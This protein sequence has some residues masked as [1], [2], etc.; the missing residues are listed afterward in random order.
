M[1]I[2]GTDLVGLHHLVFEIVDNSV[3]EC[4]NKYATTISI[5]INADG[6]VTCTD[7]GRGIPVG[8]MT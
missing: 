7:N 8:T 2:G 1:Y 4:V 5:K 6:S 3:D